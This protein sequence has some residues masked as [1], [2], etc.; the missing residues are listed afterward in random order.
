MLKKEALYVDMGGFNHREKKA[1]IG[2]IIV[3]SYSYDGFFLKDRKHPNWR[4][5]TRVAG[6]MDD[7]FNYI[8]TIVPHRIA[9]VNYSSPLVA[10]F[11]IKR[12]N[13]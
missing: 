7:N 4:I 9:K 6:C 11:L 3:A 2:E 5:C 1:W 8:F 10:L 13:I 12:D